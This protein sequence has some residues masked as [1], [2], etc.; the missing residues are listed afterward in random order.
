MEPF[1][2]LIRETSLR[3]GDLMPSCWIPRF[4]A[5]FSEVRDEARVIQAEEADLIVITQSCDLEQAKTS[6]V[7]MCPVWS[8][9]AFEQAQTS[10]GRAKSAKVWA[11][12]WNNV[13]KGRSPTLH[14]LASP[15][16]PN[17]ARAALLFDFRAIYSLP[18]DYYEPLFPYPAVLCDCTENGVRTA[19]SELEFTSILGEVLQSPKLRGVIAALRR[20]ATDDEPEIPRRPAVAEEHTR[21]D[22]PF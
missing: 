8:I 1:W 17:D 9:P 2:T 19:E 13:R 7:A 22:I 12:Y 6:L 15:T 10:S 5:D 20:Q 18:V 21:D 11:D 16:A 14:L 3:Q 4:P